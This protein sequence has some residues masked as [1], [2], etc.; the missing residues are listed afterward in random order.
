MLK[1]GRRGGVES[2]R[3]GAAS[4]WDE[5]GGMWLSESVETSDGCSACTRKFPVECDCSISGGG[6]ST[7]RAIGVNAFSS[8]SKSKLTFYDDTKDLV[9]KPNGDLAPRFP[10]SE[11]DS[12]SGSNSG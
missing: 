3:E 7:G 12:S 10:C 8:P 5:V 9:D 1:D 4:K 11:A 2:S 6:I